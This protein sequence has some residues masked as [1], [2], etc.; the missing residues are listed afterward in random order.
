[1]WRGDVKIF[2][3]RHAMP[4]IAVAACAVAVVVASPAYA[5]QTTRYV[6]GANCSDTGSG[7]Q[8]QPYCTIKAAAAAVTAGQTVLVSRGTYAGG[9]SVTHSGTATAPIVLQP[10]GGAAV[11]VS[12]GTNGFLVS[13]RSYVT[14]RGFI[15]TATTGYG[16]SVAS[17][18]HITIS[19]NTV[20]H[21]GHPVS[22]QTAGGIKLSGTTAS[23][24]SRN[25]TDHNSDHGIFINSSS[26]GNRAS[27]NEASFNAE[28]YQR[29][30]NGINVTGPNNSLIGNVVHDNEDSGLQF[31]PGANN[32]LAALNVSYNNGDHGID[33]LNVT[34]GRLIGNTVYHNCTSGINVEG[35]SGSYT[36]EN[37]I[38]VDNAV[39]PAYKGIACSRRAGN[40][41]IWDS[42]PAT[43]T[44][45]SN[46]V[47][48]SK[49]GTMYVFG[50]S[51]TSLAAMR[52]ATG[53][54]LHGV[55]ASPRFA[56][57]SGGSLRLTEGSPAIDAAN[58]GVSG[59]QT[60]DILGA[61][62]VDDPRVANT[63]IGPRRYDD[64][65]AY[66][67]G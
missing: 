17:S 41:G 31:Y 4:M 49:S 40:I 67:F 43:T 22:G 46:L 23:T 12:G 20:T 24:V 63:G 65:G 10:A 61:A 38:A 13:G 55:Q 21:A 58:S 36:V 64:I 11:T 60:L 57:A 52:A 33:D 3:K 30:A 37:N 56:N 2:P 48:L 53:Q 9:V 35:T 5:A 27:G 6:G 47:Y 66:E 19:G 15:V 54:E 45:D 1:M 51:Y 32:G 7:T 16:I 28:G 62:R 8:S 42:A 25:T 29:N 18:S 39:Y 14:I 59:E 26:S 50:S 44:V 34:G